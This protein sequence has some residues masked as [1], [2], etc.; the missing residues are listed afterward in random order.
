MA[1]KF[2]MI[3]A[4][5][6]P[7][8]PRQ[9]RATAANHLMTHGASHRSLTSALQPRTTASHMPSHTS[10]STYAKGRRH[11]AQACAPTR[12]TQTTLCVRKPRRGRISEARQ[13]KFSD[14]SDP[15][16]LGEACGGHKLDIGGTS[17]VPGTI[18][19]A[20]WLNQPSTLIGDERSCPYMISG[21][22]PHSV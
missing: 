3:I 11:K 12:S 20:R 8:A 4:L 14:A 16:P 22:V 18:E 19:A 2:A 7:V 6:S 13:G 1:E 5:K 21:L 9:S 10:A 17:F 15:P